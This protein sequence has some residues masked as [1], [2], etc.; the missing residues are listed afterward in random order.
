[1]QAL[2]GE[3]SF[4][5]AWFS[6]LKIVFKT[7]YTRHFG[8]AVIHQLKK[9]TKKPVFLGL[10]TVVLF[11]VSAFTFLWLS[12]LWNSEAAPSETE[13]LDVHICAR[14]A[15]V[16]A[17]LLSR[18]QRGRPAQGLTGVRSSN[19]SKM[20]SWRTLCEPNRNLTWLCGRPPLHARSA[21]GSSEMAFSFLLS[22]EDRRKGTFSPSPLSL[23]PPLPLCS[24]YPSI[25]NPH[26]G[27]CWRRGWKSTAAPRSLNSN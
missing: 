16:W 21:S 20:C 10:E 19:S 18:P 7:L 23:S 17:D 11:C 15:S 13:L 25:P 6:N 12:R 14:F 9:K 4:P 26:R 24:P 3:Q 2:P 27:S 22:T 5:R 1:M 8:L